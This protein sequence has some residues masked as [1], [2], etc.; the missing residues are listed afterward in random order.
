MTD[1]ER[2]ELM[3]CLVCV[4]NDDYIYDILAGW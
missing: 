3:E 1:E 4:D 2:F